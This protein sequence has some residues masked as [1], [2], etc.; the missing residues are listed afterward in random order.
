MENDTNDDKKID[1]AAMEKR[2]NKRMRETK[3][4]GKLTAKRRKFARAVVKHGEYTKA[5]KEAFDVSPDTKISSVHNQA[6][7][8]ASIPVVK[9]EIDR[10]FQDAGLTMTDVLQ[11]HRRNMTQDVHLPTSQRAVTDYYEL[12]GLKKSAQLPNIAIAFVINRGDGNG[13]EV[14]PRSI[15]RAV[16]DMSIDTQ[17]NDQIIDQ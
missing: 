12:M 9:A 2:N 15:G 13:V 7:K 17:D 3:N 8:T 11:I 6:S 1:L 16:D 14:Q 5:Y 10:L 4:P